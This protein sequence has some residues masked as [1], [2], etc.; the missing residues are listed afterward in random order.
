MRAEYNNNITLVRTVEPS[1]SETLQ[2]ADDEYYALMVI[3]RGRKDNP[4]CARPDS[5]YFDPETD[6]IG[7]ECRSDKHIYISKNYDRRHSLN[8]G[9]TW[10]VRVKDPCLC[11]DLLH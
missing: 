6:D 1:E 7:L 2:L 8:R 5:F 11:V 3:D 4:S 9:E 10:L